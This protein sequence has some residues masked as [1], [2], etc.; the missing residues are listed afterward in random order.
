MNQKVERVIRSHGILSILQNS[1][2][3]GFQ[4]VITGDELWLLLYDPRDS[5]KASSRDEVQERVSETNHTEKCRISFLWS[6][7]GIHSLVDV[8]KG[9]THNSAFFCDTAVPSLFDGIILHSRRKS[10]RGVYIQPDN[11]PPHDARRSTECLHAKKIQ[12]ITHPAYSPDLAPS[13]FFLFGSVKRKLT[14]YDIPGRQCLRCDCRNVFGTLMVRVLR[15]MI[16]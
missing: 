12:R 2:S 6:V 13:D 8:P 10:L 1:G 11:A 4:S 15:R 14:E 9:S 3:A 5:I 16:I 7:N